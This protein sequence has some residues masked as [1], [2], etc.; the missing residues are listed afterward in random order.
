MSTTSLHESRLQLKMLR[1]QHF[2]C[3]V[4][5][6][7]FG[8]LTRSPVLVYP[9]TVALVSLC[10]YFIVPAKLLKPATDETDSRSAPA[11]SWPQGPSNALPQ[12]CEMLCCSSMMHTF[13]QTFVDAQ[14]RD[15]STR[16]TRPLV[17]YFLSTTSHANTVQSSR[18]TMG[19]LRRDHGHASCAATVCAC[20]FQTP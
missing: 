6:L 4:Q 17:W 2:T 12:P 5:T 14:T 18:Q 7:Y 9:H 8:P 3:Q 20:L 1:L 10:R 13:Q 16:S 15:D 19:V 11:V